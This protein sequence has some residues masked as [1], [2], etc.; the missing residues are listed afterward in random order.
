M[1]GVVFHHQLLEE[2]IKGSAAQG[3]RVRLLQKYNSYRDARGMVEAA[4]SE[5]E[6]RDCAR[7]VNEQLSDL[8]VAQ[9]LIGLG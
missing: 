2:V 7:H 6:L 9:I 8:Y 4:I 5:E 1:C 3:L